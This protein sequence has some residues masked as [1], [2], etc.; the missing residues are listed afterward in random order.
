MRCLDLMEKLLINSSQLLTFQNQTIYS[1]NI[2]SEGQMPF[3]QK[4][5]INSFVLELFEANWIDIPG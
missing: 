5:I 4:L 1:W 2:L 3:Y